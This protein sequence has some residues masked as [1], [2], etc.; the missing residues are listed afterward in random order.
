MTPGVPEQEGITGVPGTKALSLHLLSL[1]QTEPF[2][3]LNSPGHYLSSSL[4]I[5]STSIM[6][7]ID[8]WHC[9]RSSNVSDISVASISSLLLLSS[10]IN[11]RLIFSLTLLLL[12]IFW[13]HFC[14]LTKMKT[15]E[16]SQ[17]NENF[18]IT[19]STVEKLPDPHINSNTLDTSPK[20]LYLLGGKIK[21][22]NKG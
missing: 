17:N 2:N 14:N 7:V 6:I 5:A 10:S 13:S 18:L 22:I 3:P 15:M 8:H 16:W 4:V 21:K 20:Y 1:H 11:W 9:I 12:P 19:F